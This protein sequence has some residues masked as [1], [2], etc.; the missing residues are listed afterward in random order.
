MTPPGLDELPIVE[1]VRF[2]SGGLLL[3][4]ELSYPEQPQ[5]RAGVVVAGPHPLLGGTM[6]NNVVAALTHG[7]ARRGL[8]TLRFNYRGTGQ[9][10]G[11]R[12]DGL[13]NLAEF[14]ATSR[15]GEEPAYRSDLISA[16]GF[17][18]EVL[19]EGTPVAAVGYSFGCS[20]LPL[21]AESGVPL[22]LIA[23]TIGTHEYEAFTKLDNPLLVI[24]SEDDFAAKVDSLQHWFDRLSAPRRLERGRFD[25]HFFRGHEQW[26]ADTV[27]AFLEAQ[28]SVG[29]C[30]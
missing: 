9:S 29:P 6:R 1:S 2:P 8:A 20:L 7:L 3:E 10:E 4:G 19:G 5:P 11:P 28:G 26:L 15:L 30:Q 12:V 17:L 14:W 21:V 16:C 27:F 24:V 22:V 23:P 13:N 18:R 25:N